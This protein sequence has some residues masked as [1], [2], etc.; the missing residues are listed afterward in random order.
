MQKTLSIEVSKPL[1]SFDFQLNKTFF[2]SG[3]TAILGV[4]GSGKS[5]FLNLINGRL[6]PLRGKI[7]INDQVLVDTQKR[8]N[9]PIHQRNIATVFQDPLLFPH[10]SVRKN[11]LYGAKNKPDAEFDALTQILQ[12][13]DKLDRYPANLSGGEK[14]RVAIGRAFLNRPRL[15]LMDEPLSSLDSPRKKELIKY[16]QLLKN[17][18]AVPIFFVSH[19]L[20]EVRLLADRIAIIEQGKLTHFG[21]AQAILKLPFLQDWL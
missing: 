20:N 4:S 1:A 2:L 17:E 13:E 11:L 12:L 10:F 19:N 9:V 15:L 5:T 8:I 7:I 3:L 16:I 14:Q 21:E 6:S 18:F